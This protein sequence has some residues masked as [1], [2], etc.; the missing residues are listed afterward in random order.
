MSPGSDHP[1]SQDEHSPLSGMRYST[2]AHD[3]VRFVDD[4]VDEELAQF[5][6]L[7]AH[8]TNER[9]AAIRAAIAKEDAY[10][11]LAFARRRA[12]TALRTGSLTQGLEAVRSLTLVTRSRIDYRDLSVDFQL[13]QCANSVV[14]SMQSSERPV[15][16][17]IRAP[18][19]ASWRDRRRRA[20]RR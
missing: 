4:P 8:S 20:P 9:R 13:T 3:V 11:L 5:V 15:R 14:I 19:S 7:A 2:R 6:G 16:S 10:T 12:V 1:E 18:A 17:A